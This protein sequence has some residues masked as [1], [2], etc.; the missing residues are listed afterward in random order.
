M[1]RTGAI[2]LP[3][4]AP[5][6]LLPLARSAEGAGLDELWVWEDCFKHSGVASASACLA[7]TTR[8]TIGLGLMPAP[9]RNVALTAMEVATLERMFPGRFRPG[10]G[11]G[12]QS[13]MEQAGVRA[14]SPLT[15]LRE[16]ITALRA[17]LDGQRVSAQ[18]RYVRLDDVAL[19]WPPLQHVPLLAGAEGP[20]SLQLSGA[21]AEGTILPAG[22]TVDRLRGARAQIEVGR[23]QAGRTDHH[24]IT[25]FV[26][27]ATGP[28]AHQRL[29]ACRDRWGFEGAGWGAAGD[30]EQVAHS[31]RSWVLAGADALALQ[32]TDDDPDPAAFMAFAG[33]VALLLR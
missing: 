25:V 15:L 2:F 8:I 22:T 19:D 5:E 4:W 31:L 14:V 21:L 30:A 6:S 27:V 23:K 29:E 7:A 24:D 32:P 28:G 10:I 11:H 12:V 17:L 26:P 3:N 33:E 16:Q 13:W 18:G 9:L 20:K 1:T